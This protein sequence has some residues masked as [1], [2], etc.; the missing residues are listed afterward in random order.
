[1][2]RRR[3]LALTGLGL[4][5]LGAGCTNRGGGTD[6]PKSTP[7][8]TPAGGGGTATGTRASGGTLEV[9][10]TNDDDVAHEVRVTVTNDAG[11]VVEEAYTP[12]LEPGDYTMFGG[13][14][15]A[16]VYTVTVETGTETAT[17]EWDTGE[18]ER[19]HLDVRITDD[20]SQSHAVDLCRA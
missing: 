13:F 1:M 14:S 2:H 17:H 5:G 12:E 3:F 15:P 10:V 6:T 8:P 9:T 19:I 20:G 4:A 16:G 11:T 7:T 18:C